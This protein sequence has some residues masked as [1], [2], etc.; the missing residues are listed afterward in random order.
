MKIFKLIII[1]LLISLLIYFGIVTNK[2]LKQKIAY[3]EQHK[4]VKKDDIISGVVKSKEVIKR[5]SEIYVKLNNNQKLHF[6]SVRNDNYGR[7][8]IFFSDF[9]M[10]HDSIHKNK[11]DD[12]IYLHRKDSVYYFFLKN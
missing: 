12:K 1:L 7:Q 9:V 11:Y 6:K 4:L 10:I 3:R 8:N 2:S 5:G